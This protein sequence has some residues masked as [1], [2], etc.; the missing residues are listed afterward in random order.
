MPRAGDPARGLLGFQVYLDG[1]L[2]FAET[3]PFTGNYLAYA[4]SSDGWLDAKADS[5][6]VDFPASGAVFASLCGESADAS[7]GSVG[8][9]GDGALDDIDVSDEAPA[10][11]GV[12]SLDFT[13]DFT[14][15]ESAVGY[16]VGR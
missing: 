14:A 11:I 10:F 8:F 1:V 2:L 4:T 3:P 9:R 16:A 15:E 12:D 7:V 5:E 13:L 6:L